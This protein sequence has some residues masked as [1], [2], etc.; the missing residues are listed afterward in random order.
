ML[1]E[2]IAV[3]NTWCQWEKKQVSM[4][5]PSYLANLPIQVFSVNLV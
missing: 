5:L 1:R 4:P 2:I 3:R